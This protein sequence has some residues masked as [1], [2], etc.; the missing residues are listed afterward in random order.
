MTLSM[1]Q[2]SIPV[3]VHALR[4]LRQVLEKGL[5][6]AGEK[7]IE[8]AVLLNMRLSPDMFPLVRQVRIATDMAKNGAAR[9][10]GAELLRF[11]DDEL[12]FEELFA[13]IDRVLDYLGTFEAARIDGSEGRPIRVMAGA[14]G[15]LKFDG[16]SYLLGFV[17]PNLYFHAATA[18][19]ILR[20]AGVPLGKGDFLGPVGQD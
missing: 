20:H 18:Y 17:L 19:G 7:G 4:Q 6:H 14:R 8:P 12:S 3:F 1:Y 9:L 10:A 15:E 11:E 5:A 16:R 13:R 2:A